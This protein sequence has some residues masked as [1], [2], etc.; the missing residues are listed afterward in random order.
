VR[1]NLQAWQSPVPTALWA[2]LK[3]EG[4]IRPESIQ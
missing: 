1:D 2:D 4:L 3:S